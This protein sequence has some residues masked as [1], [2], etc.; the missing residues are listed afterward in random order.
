ME[1]RLLHNECILSTVLRVNKSNYISKLINFNIKSS[2]T[3]MPTKF[4][5][6]LIEIKS[7]NATEV[8]LF[9][10]TIYLLHNLNYFSRKQELF[11][12]SITKKIQQ[13][14]IKIVQDN[15]A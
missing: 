1:G 6:N 2:L 12:V 3:E 11:Y 10:D 14:R 9:Q 4:M 13:I 5:F 15:L 7:I 8:N